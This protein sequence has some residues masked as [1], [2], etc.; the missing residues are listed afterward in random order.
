ME[1]LTHYTK[2]SSVTAWAVTKHVSEVNAVVPDTMLSV[3]YIIVHA[4]K[5]VNG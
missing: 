2:R 5:G 4:V 1:E 3:G